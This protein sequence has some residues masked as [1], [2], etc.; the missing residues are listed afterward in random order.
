MRIIL[1]AFTVTLLLAG[2]CLAQ[3]CTEENAAALETCLADAKLACEASF[4]SCEPAAVTVED[5][6]ALLSDRCGSC[7]EVKNF[8]KYNSCLKQVRNSIRVLKALSEEIQTALADQRQT[9][10]DA[11]KANK[12]KKKGAQEEDSPESES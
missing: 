4:P 7:E 10:K 12:G 5:A 2:S 1:T 11:I 3:T 6:L 8:G 9:C